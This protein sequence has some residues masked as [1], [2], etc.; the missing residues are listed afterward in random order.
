GAKDSALLEIFLE[1]REPAPVVAMAQVRHRVESFK[2]VAALVDVA[3]HA[4]PR[5][6]R[7]PEDARLPA[8]VED[9]LPRLGLDPAK[10]VHPAHVVNAI[11][12]ESPPLVGPCQ[13]AGLIIVGST[14]PERR[15]ARF[16]RRAARLTSRGRRSRRGPPEGLGREALE[17]SRGRPRPTTGSDGRP[18]KPSRK[19]SPLPAAG[20]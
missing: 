6:E 8:R 13:D 15:P 7:D 14:F 5:E 20:G 12:P 17:R 10:A 16:E 19:P 4:Q 11:H 9:R 18:I 3:A 1:S 2:A